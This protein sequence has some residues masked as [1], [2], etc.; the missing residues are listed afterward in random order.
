MIVE[1]NER[2]ET[3][4]DPNVQNALNKNM[5][6]ASA[7]QMQINALQKLI[8][9][10]REEHRMIQESQ[11]R[12]SHY[13]QQ[14][15][16][17]RY[18]DATIEYFEHLIKDERSKVRCG[19]PRTRLYQ[20]ENDKASY[21]YFVTAMKMGKQS[22]G[23]GPL[24]ENGVYALVEKLYAMKHYGKNLKDCAKKTGQA[25]AATFRERPYR[26]RSRGTGWSGVSDI[27]NGLY[28][29]VSTSRGPSPVASL[30]KVNIPMRLSD[31]VAP[32]KPN[33]PSKP[34]RLSKTQPK[35]VTSAKW[36]QEYLQRANPVLVSNIAF[37]DSD[38]SDNEGFGHGGDNFRP[39]EIIAQRSDAHGGVHNYLFDKEPANTPD[40]MTPPPSYKSS[41]SRQNKAQ[42]F[43]AQDDEDEADRSN[44]CQSSAA[45]HSQTEADPISFNNTSSDASPALLARTMPNQV[46][47]AITCVSCVRSFLYVNKLLMSCRPVEKW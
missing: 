36:F 46:I 12:F 47:W 8:K 35:E 32:S 23:R 6:D 17:T 29:S 40:S 10:L 28:S 18:N 24:N 43:R 1:Y 11:A 44:Q 3:M 16:I 2:T 31:S 9:E 25:Y 30:P 20:L 37:P 45:Q 27:F 22:T 42:N 4:T 38:D 41:P 33:N 5:D 26:V 21:E 19:M 34:S 14:H 13:L 7:K 39:P 15:S